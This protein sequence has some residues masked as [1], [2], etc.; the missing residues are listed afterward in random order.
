MSP[1]NLD[2]DYEKLLENNLN[3]VQQK[4][5]EDPQYF[6]KLAQ[7]QK[8]RFLWIG[9]S[10][11]RI[12]PNEV[13]GT[14]PGEIFVHRNIANLVVNTDLNMLS[15]LQYAVEVLQVEHVIVCGHY[16]CG[17][18]NA[19]LEN[20]YHGLIDKW[21]LNIKDTYRLYYRE[22]DAIDDP[23]KRSRRMVEINV[24][25]QVYNLA[26][27]DIIQ[28]AWQ[29]GTRPHLHGWVYDLN[30]GIIN[31]MRISLADN[32]NLLKIYKV[33]FPEPAPDKE[34]QKTAPKQADKRSEELLNS[35]QR[36]R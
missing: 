17:G 4:R 36:T 21:L 30:D 23:Q 26:K 15:V 13:T 6:H 7:I 19:A 12:P 11:S 24:M 10:D 34:A 31:D 33:L 16:G 3:W 1:D 8:P 20:R 35:N 28:R 5:E 25:E 18:I 9:C 27:T 14:Q 2:E 29:N 32:R 22:L